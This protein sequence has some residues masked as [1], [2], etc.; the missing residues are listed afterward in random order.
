MFSGV[1]E[2]FTNDTCRLADVLVNDGGGDDFEEVGVEGGS[3]GSGEESFASS[4]RAIEED[5]FWRFYS[6]AFEEFG[7]EEGEFD[8][9]RI[10]R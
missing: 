9:L 8:N 10:G 5:A 2:H 7:V 3:D 6:N 1:S 4:W